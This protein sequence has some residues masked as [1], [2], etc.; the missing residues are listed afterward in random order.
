MNWHICHKRKLLFCSYFHHISLCFYSNFERE[1]SLDAEFN[2]ASNEYTNNILLMDPPTPK[3]RNTW[4]KYDDDV[5]ITFFSGVSCFWGSGVHQKY[6]EWILV[7][8]KILI[9][10]PM[11]SPDWNLS[12]NMGRYVKNTNK[13]VVFSFLPPKL[14]NIILLF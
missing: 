10:H 4:K 8:C 1:S 6:A 2:Y 12:K 9:P 14:I 5:I 11:S 7:G 13:K 3:T